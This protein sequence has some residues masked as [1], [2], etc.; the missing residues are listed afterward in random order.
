MPQ[1]IKA[2]LEEILKEELNWSKE[3]YIA[4]IAEELDS[5]QRL[6]LMVAIEDHY[7]IIFEPTDEANIT[8][9]DDLI[10]LIQTKLDQDAMK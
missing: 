6:S 2:V 7:Q 1:T 4:N 8:S 10:Q 3:S 5:M 9:S